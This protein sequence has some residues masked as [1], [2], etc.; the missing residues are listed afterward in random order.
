MLE[1][2][3]IEQVLR[4]QKQKRKAQRPFLEI[5]PA[6]PPE[7]RHAPEEKKDERGVTIVDYRV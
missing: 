7:E 2:W 5:P 3:I 6:P 4:R 1:P